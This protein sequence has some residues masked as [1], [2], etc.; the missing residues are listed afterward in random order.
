M[1]TRHID[2]PSDRRRHRLPDDHPAVVALRRQREH[3]RLLESIVEAARD[4][5]DRAMYRAMQALE[6]A[7]AQPGVVDE[8]PPS[9]T[10]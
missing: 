5:N 7:E 1:E 8:G 2:R 4:N 6:Q 9:T 3:I 10:P